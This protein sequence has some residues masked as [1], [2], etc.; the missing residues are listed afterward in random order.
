MPENQK[1]IN[2]LNQELSN[3]AV[4]YIKLH[5]YHW[6]VQGRHFFKLHE[7]FEDLYN[8]AAED[9]DEVAERILAIDGKPLAT[10]HKYIK[11]TTL[12]EAQADDKENEIINQLSE[13]YRTMIKEI[14][15]IGIPLAEEIDDQPTSDLLNDIRGRFEKHVWML[16]A[17]IAYE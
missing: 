16:R 12:H 6:F 9:L 2:F 11:E 3:F 13:D 8:E 17:Y 5:R 7:V 4:L 10:M 15:E 14:K 1:L